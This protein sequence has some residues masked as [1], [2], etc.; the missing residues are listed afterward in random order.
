MRTVGFSF[1]LLSLSGFLLTLSGGGEQHSLIIRYLK[2]I[3]CGS[4]PAP[5]CIN[6]GAAFWP[7][8]LLQA[9]LSCDVNSWWGAENKEYK[10]AQS[11]ILNTRSDGALDRDSLVIFLQI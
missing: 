5:N 1:S 8:V 4:S 10:P 2:H 9:P 11:L 7:L 3:N 6:L